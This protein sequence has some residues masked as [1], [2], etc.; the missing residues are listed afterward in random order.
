MPVDFLGRI[1]ADSV[2]DPSNWVKMSINFRCLTEVRQLGCILTITRA[3]R[4]KANEITSRARTVS[5]QRFLERAGII[6]QYTQFVDKH[7]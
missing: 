5:S 3:Q 1:V 2:K 4:F 7:R 6:N